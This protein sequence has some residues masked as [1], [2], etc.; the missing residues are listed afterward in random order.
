M[1]FWCWRLLK[2]RGTSSCAKDTL[3]IVTVKP[4]TITSVSDWV[5][6]LLCPFLPKVH[7]VPKHS[8]CMSRSETRKL[9]EIMKKTCILLDK[10][11]IS[12]QVTKCIKIFNSNTALPM[13]NNT[14]TPHS[15]TCRTSKPAEPILVPRRM[16]IAMQ[17]CVQTN[18]VCWA[19]SAWDNSIKFTSPRMD[20]DLMGQPETSLW[21][22]LTFP[23]AGLWEAM[24][25]NRVRSTTTC[26]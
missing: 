20:L 23:N 19:V 15:G 11:K 10:A 26:Y 5:F 17:C 12:F 13:G 22:T 6:T 3:E 14:S 18:T 8:V 16:G 9:L 25:D 2:R 7:T 24:D 21:M 4:T 1:Q